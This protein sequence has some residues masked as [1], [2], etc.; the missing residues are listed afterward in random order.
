VIGILFTGGTISM[1]IDPRS[2]AATPALGGHEIL[3]AAGLAGLTDVLVEDF[4]RLPGP[5]VTPEQMWRLARRAAAWLE[6]PDVD[7]LVIAHGTDTI[8]ETC[9]FLDL[10]LTSSKPVVFVGAMRTVSEPSWDGPANLLAAVRVAGSAES[11][12]RGTLV[13][14]NEQI[15]AAAEA[16][17]THTEAAASFTSPEFGPL[18]VVDAGTVLYRRAATRVDWPAS[19]DADA[20]LRL[21]R[22]EPAVDLI[23]A[24][25]GLDDRYIR[26]SLEL[27]ARGLVIEA[28]GRGNVPP[29]MR[30]GIAEAID[31]GV[32]VVVV[33]RCVTGRVLDRYGYEGGGY[34]LRRLGAI[35]GGGLS[36]PKARIRLMVALGSSSD[37]AAI[38]RWFE[39]EPPWR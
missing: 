13:V 24:V 32:P 25:A 23:K 15:L 36:G 6:R 20:G 11:R 18:G 39:G 9:A 35:L 10:V 26:C 33:S 19:P 1:R 21:A 2:G 14:M 7:G 30:P 22:I 8:E 5:H 38:R 16:L 28:M 12:G 17:K 4:S 27:G 37:P 29:P 34:D 3:E 31:R